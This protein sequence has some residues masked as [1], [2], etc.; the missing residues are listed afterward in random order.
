MKQIEIPQEDYEFLKELQNELNTQPSDGNAQPVYWGVLEDYEALT[1]EG[2]G[3]ARIPHDDG[4]YSLEELVGE[5]NDDSEFFSLSLKSEWNAVDKN[6]LDEVM[7]FVNKN[8]NERNIIGKPYWVEIKDKICRDAGAFLTKRAC[9]EYIEK[10]GYNHRNPRTYAMTAY[11]NFE[12]ERL[13][14]ILRTIK[15]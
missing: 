9:K 14:N 3:E 6:D 15:F 5:I 4:A 11:R 2:E 7:D 1:F 13:L 12:L 10:F 8:W